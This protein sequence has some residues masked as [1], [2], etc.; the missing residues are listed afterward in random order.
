[1]LNRSSDVVLLTLVVLAKSR[2]VKPAKATK[3]DGW[4]DTIKKENW[5]AER[6]QDEA[7]KFILE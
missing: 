7:R 3:V 1:M 6:K 2:A 4:L 5:Q